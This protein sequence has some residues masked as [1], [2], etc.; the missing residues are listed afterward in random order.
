[1]P[2][3]RGHLGNASWFGGRAR[4]LGFAAATFCVLVGGYATI[5]RVRAEAWEA[6]GLLPA[7]DERSGGC[8]I[9]FIGSSTVF[10]WQTLSRDFPGWDV[11]NRGVYGA[12]IPQ[13][14]RWFGNEHDGDR[15]AAIV[16]YAG[17][18]DLATGVPTADA[19]ADFRRFMAAKSTRF[20]G[21]PVIALSLKPSPGR[22]EY[23]P[24]Q[25]A[26]NNALARYAATRS[27]LGYVD[28]Q[29]LMLS[30]GRPGPYFVADG[31]HMSQ[32]GY[33]RWSPT[34]RTALATMLPRRT[35]ERCTTSKPRR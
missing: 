34:L 19:F 24:A 28:I 27:D 14:T 17:E 4:K 2:G 32:R 26:F 1:M 31:V 10:R 21:L 3:L 16:F 15:P 33:D 11:H 22:W 35:V 20:D 5:E 8:S 9:W 25:L 30:N 12:L 7:A 18:N 29:P 6:N 13:I 23:R